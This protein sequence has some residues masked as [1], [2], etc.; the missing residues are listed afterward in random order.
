MGDI[1]DDLRELI[2]KKRK[3]HL[4]T[5]DPPWNYKDKAKAG[6]RGAADQYKGGTMTIEDLMDMGELVDAVTHKDSVLLMWGTWPLST[7]CRVLMRAW[8]FKFKTCAFVWVKLCKKKRKLKIGMGHYSRSNTEYVLLGVKKGGKALPV[9]DK[10]IQQVIIDH[11]RENSRKPDEYF[12]RVDR[13]FGTKIK[14]LELF[15]REPRKRWTVLGD[16]VDK[17]KGA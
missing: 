3:F 10:G 17:F 12:N 14:R 9:L 16:E 2:K 7:E 11:V 6:K 1:R 15:G 8:G 4:V 5:A 13:M